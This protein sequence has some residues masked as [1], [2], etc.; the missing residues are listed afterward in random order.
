MMNR[1]SSNQSR[2]VNL[3][4]SQPDQSLL[5]FWLNST[6]SSP[7][8]ISLLSSTPDTRRDQLD[9]RRDVDG[10]RGVEYLTMP[11]SSGLNGPDSDLSSGDPME[12]DSCFIQEPDAAHFPKELLFS[13]GNKNR[14]QE[15]LQDNRVI[16]LSDTVKR[17]CTVNKLGLHIASTGI[18]FRDQFV[19]AAGIATSRKKDSEQASAFFLLR[20]LQRIVSADDSRKA[21]PTGL[22]S[23]SDTK[24]SPPLDAFLQ[25]QSISSSSSSS[26]SSSLAS[27]T[28]M[29]GLAPTTSSLAMSSSE[30][31]YILSWVFPCPM[32]VGSRSSFLTAL[33][34]VP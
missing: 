6:S 33:L 34:H 24:S 30:V 21:T 19:K 1:H 26:S 16:I 9:I 18:L 29:L 20:K 4:S 17:R 8:R 12:D 32:Q 25:V 31:R 3:S 7:H 28:T 10:K 27:M 23:S 11:S 5:P 14:L 13:E 2:V 15:F 22:Y